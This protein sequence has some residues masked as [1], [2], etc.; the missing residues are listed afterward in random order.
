MGNTGGRCRVL[1]R[2]RRTGTVHLGGRAVMKRRGDG[3][4]LLILLVVTLIA[5]VLAAEGI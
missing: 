3:R 2:S 4:F 1:L 5:L